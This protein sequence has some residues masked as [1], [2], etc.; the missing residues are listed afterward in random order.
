MRESEIQ[1]NNADPVQSPKNLIKYDTLESKSLSSKENLDKKKSERLPVTS[2]MKTPKIEQFGELMIECL[3]WASVRVDSSEFDTTPL[4]KPIRLSA[5]FHNLYLSHPNYPIYSRRISINPEELL[6]IKVNLDT[7]MGYLDCQ[8]YPWGE[9]F[10]N[11]RSIG[12]TP[13]SEVYPLRP[14]EYE[15]V[16][17]NPQFPDHQDRVHIF[18]ADT[19]VYKYHFKHTRISDKLN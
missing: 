17:R 6:T 19:L 12:Q 5:G 9:V 10:V 8:I 15:L 1:E 11:N 13:L 14:G 18:K 16:I 4:S 3:P 7:L 2:E